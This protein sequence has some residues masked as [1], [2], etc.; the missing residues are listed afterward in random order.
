MSSLWSGLPGM[1][2]GLPDSVLAIASEWN[3]KLN[4]ALR[5]TPPWQEIHL[6][7]KIG[8]T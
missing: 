2:A 1:I 8:F 6:L 5:L 7:L 4:P 3:N